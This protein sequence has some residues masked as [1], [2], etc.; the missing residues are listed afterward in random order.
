MNLKVLSYNYYIIRLEINFLCKLLKFKF[1]LHKC[2]IFCFI[3][4]LRQTWTVFGVSVLFNFHQDET[5]LKQYA[6]RLREEVANASTQE[7]VS[8][9]TEFTVMKNITL[10]PSP[11]DLP[12]IKVLFF[13]SF[14]LKA[15]IIN[16]SSLFLFLHTIKIITDR[17]LW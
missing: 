12:P 2:Y 16:I 11:E 15:N 5:H 14:M 7:N 10:R 13:N 6:K 3:G 8:Y 9:I 17:S 4:L 1:K